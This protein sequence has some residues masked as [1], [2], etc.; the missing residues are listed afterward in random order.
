MF[1]CTMSCDERREHPGMVSVSFF[2]SPQS[3]LWGT[4]E[5]G[6]LVTVPCP[7]GYCNCNYNIDMNILPDNTTTAICSSV[8]QLQ[9][10]DGQCVCSRQGYLCGACRSG[11]SVTAL[12]NTCKSCDN[13]WIIGIVVLSKPRL[14]SPPPVLRGDC[15]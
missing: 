1:T 3:G 13:T 12:L 4:A 11:M 2:H 10:P 15:V 8:L 6:H 14:Q 7:P 9:H 5:R